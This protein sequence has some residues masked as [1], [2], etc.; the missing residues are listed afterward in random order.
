MRGKRND[1]DKSY[2][3]KS[4]KNALHR[5]ELSLQ[6]N[7]S[8]IA[9]FKFLWDGNQKPIESPD[10]PWGIKPSRS[11][12]FPSS[13]ITHPQKTSSLLSPPK[14]ILI[15]KNHQNRPPL[16]FL[17]FSLSEKASSSPFS[18]SF[19]TPTNPWK[20]GIFGGFGRVVAVSGCWKYKEKKRI[21]FFFSL[22]SLRRGER[23]EEGLFILCVLSVFR[24][25][26]I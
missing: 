21:F 23:E 20:M 10:G 11:S 22:F 18:F 17:F 7:F 25:G 19:I 3:C 14:P 9:E 26:W 12:S 16:P 6:N 24:W 1:W 8:G 13:L 15:S 4:A 2:F 5:Q